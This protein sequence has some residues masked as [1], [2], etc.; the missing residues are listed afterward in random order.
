MVLA[1]L[2]SVPRNLGYLALFA[3]VGMESS[4]I[5]VPGET[6]L[7]AAGVTASQHHL[8]IVAV[9]VVAAVAAIL[10]DNLGYLIGRRL[11]RR[12]LTRPG[13]TL[14]RRLAALERGQR[15]FDRHGPKAVFFGRWVAGLRIWASWLAGMT[16]MRWPQFLLFN[17]LGG[18]SW[19]ICFGLLSY[20]AGHAA[21]QVIER[22][23][24]GAGAVAIVA[25]IVA[26]VVVHRR[27]SRSATPGAGSPPGAPVAGQAPIPGG[28]PP[29]AADETRRG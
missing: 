3:L 2:I 19:A 18:V 26:V 6:S 12:L 11:G 25:V 8:S 23:G 13:R 7:V 29:A 22:V 14:D 21:A 20:F 9:I 17:A 28:P 27:R 15:I 1:A 5:P 4:G 10:G 24:L 16:R